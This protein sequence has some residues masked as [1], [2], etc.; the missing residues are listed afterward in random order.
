MNLP[1]AEYTLR[2][3]GS[4]TDYGTRGFVFGILGPIPTDGS[5]APIRS[6]GENPKFT[7][8]YDNNYFQTNVN[9]RL[10]GY[11]P[12]YMPTTQII[13]G[14]FDET[15]TFIP[16]TSEIIVTPATNLLAQFAA[17]S[18][19]DKAA[20][21]TLLL[22]VLG[23][24]AGEAAKALLCS[25][26]ASCPVPYDPDE[27]TSIEFDQF[28]HYEFVPI[29]VYVIQSLFSGSS[30][31][32]PGATGNW[33]ITNRYS[34]G[35]NAHYEGGGTYSIPAPKRSGLVLTPGDN[36]TA[37]LQ[38]P[39]SYLS[40]S[41]IKPVFT[42]P[43]GGPGPV[44]ENITLQGYMPRIDVEVK[45]GSPSQVFF[46]FG[47]PADWDYWPDHPLASI[48]EY[49]CA[50]GTIVPA[51]VGNINTVTLSS[52]SG[53]SVTKSI[54]IIG[55]QPRR[56]LWKADNLALST[57]YPATA[58]AS[59]TLNADGAPSHAI[60]GNTT[61]FSVNNWWNSAAI[62][63]TP[64]EHLDI[65]LGLYRS[66]SRVMLQFVPD[67]YS[68]RTNPVSDSETFTLYGIVAFRIQIPDGS[69]GW[70]TIKS[71]TANTNTRR[72]VTFPAV[73]TSLVRIQVDAITTGDTSARIMEVEIFEN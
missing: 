12:T 64:N 29:P 67:N 53:F 71:I 10:S 61:S 43:V 31:I 38:N 18:A 24:P 44:T 16:Q 17:A 15:G 66:I 63:G 11:H 26:V 57:V 37:T 50:Y 60:D 32:A 68:T 65:D 70:T 69:G 58:T 56:N 55:S 33:W 34:S 40:N 54:T 36:A 8:D 14:H 21:M 45:M 19:A 27:I 9:Y 47:C 7:R 48:D 52:P 5:D 3:D 41:V 25:T 59:S 6:Q 72:T 4:G 39:V 46:Y 73:V 20:I 13:D 51:V 62:S 30:L 35:P 23:I 28:E 2:T 1:D 22:T 49:G 42:F